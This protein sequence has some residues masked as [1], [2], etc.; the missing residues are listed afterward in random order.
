MA[1]RTTPFSDKEMRR[2]IGKATGN[3]ETDTFTEQ[4]FRTYR[5]TLYG[6]IPGRQRT[7][8][9]GWDQVVCAAQ[10]SCLRALRKARAQGHI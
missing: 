4:M 5:A 1:K 3:D 7:A 6:A 9:A 2:A 8:S 10:R